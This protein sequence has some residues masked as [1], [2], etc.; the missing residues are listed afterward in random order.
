MD[1]KRLVFRMH[2]LSRHTFAQR[3]RQ[4]GK[5][6]DIWV[7]TLHLQHLINLEM[8]HYENNS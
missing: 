7:G 5:T 6:K 3:Y 8:L 2:A 4:Q 1:P